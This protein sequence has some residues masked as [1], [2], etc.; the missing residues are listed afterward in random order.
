MKEQSAPPNVLPYGVH[1]TVELANGYRHVI[2]N[3]EMN[4]FHILPPRLYRNFRQGDDRRDVVGVLVRKFFRVG[5]TA[6]VEAFP[7]LGHSA[8]PSSVRRFSSGLG[9]GSSTKNSGSAG[10]FCRLLTKQRPVSQS[11]SA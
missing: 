8:L 11:I 9:I 3:W 6:N 10:L 4:V 1:H 2:L 5:E 7:N